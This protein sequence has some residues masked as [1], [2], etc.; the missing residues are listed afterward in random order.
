MVIPEKPLYQPTKEFLRLKFLDSF[1]NC[2]LEITADGHFEEALKK[3]V[4]QDIIFAFLKRGTSPD[5]VGFIEQEYSTKDFITVEIKS[6]QIN[7]RDIAQAKLYGDLFNAKY[8]FLISPQPIPEEIKR[9]HQ[10]LSILHRFMSGY[11]TY[12]GQLLFSP[13]TLDAMVVHRVKEDWFPESPFPTTEEEPGTFYCTEC[14][15]KII[16]DNHMDSP[17]LSSC[18]TCG[19][20]FPR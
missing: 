4:Q 17:P 9:L 13:T 19:A 1:D 8:A 20:D 11:T 14:G 12:I 7:I 15:H 16:V 10:K 3:A 6:G 5:L 18:P 2:Y